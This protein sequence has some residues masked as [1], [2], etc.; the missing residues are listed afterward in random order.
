LTSRIQ[1]NPVKIQARI[2]VVHYKSTFPALTE[3]W[4]YNQ[5]NNLDKNAA[6]VYALERGDTASF[7]FE[8][9]R[10][11]RNDLSP[12][13][14]FFNRAWYKLFKRYPH[15]FIW[16]WK[17]RPELIHAHFGICGYEILPYANWFKIPLITSFYGCDAYQIPQMWPDWCDKYKKLFLQ[18]RLFLA[19]GPAMRQKLIELGCPAEKVVVHHIGIKPENYR[20]K[21]RRPDGRIRLLV[22]GR[23]VE[24]K[25]ISYAVEAMSLLRTKTSAKVHLTIVGDS[26]SEGTL[27]EEKRKILN[28]IEKY[29]LSDLV[30]I[31]GMVSHERFMEIVYDHHICLAPSVYASDGDAEGGFP[32][33]LTEVLATGMPVAAFGHCDI[34]YIVQ[35]GKSGFIVP[36]RDTNALADKLAYLIEHPQIWSQMGQA[37]RDFV[38]QHY[39]IYKLNNRLMEIYRNVLDNQS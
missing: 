31:T 1:S 29:N 10:S 28:T 36:E 32:V 18:G 17:D 25:G 27:T 21:E 30:T 19:E 26:D 4:L 6:K 16:L 3:N 37:G 20:F 34:P 7:P 33:V 15:F 5:I 24:K 13:S 2:K 35:D 39:D 9:L 11:L 23:F 22:C 12:V 38:M 14:L 8:N